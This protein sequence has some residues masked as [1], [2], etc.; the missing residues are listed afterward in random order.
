M[1]TTY[2]EDYNEYREKLW[3]RKRELEAQISEIDSK[4]EDILH[5]LEF[6]KCDAVTMVKVTK[7]LKALRAER[8]EIKNEWADL[9]PVCKRLADKVKTKETNK[10]YKYRTD[11]IAECTGKAVPN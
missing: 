3:A 8:R 11:V 7:R 4:Q 10:I 1:S 6:E 2:R 9:E 5:F